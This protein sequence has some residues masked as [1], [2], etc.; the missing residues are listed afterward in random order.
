MS[1][2]SPERGLKYIDYNKNHQT[3]QSLRS[4]ERGL[5]FEADS[6][7]LTN[8]ESL[9]SPERGLKLKYLQSKLKAGQVAPFAGAWIEIDEFGYNLT[10]GKGRSVRRSVD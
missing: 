2:R 4:P 9:R 7:I 3:Q 8:R 6:V 10:T 5:K 1:L